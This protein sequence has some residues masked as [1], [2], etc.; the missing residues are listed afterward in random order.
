MN[1]SDAHLTH[2]HSSAANCLLFEADPGP[3][4]LNIG[5]ELEPRWVSREY[6]WR[7]FYAHDL[8]IAVNADLALLKQ[9]LDFAHQ[10]RH[11]TTSPQLTVAEQRE[12]HEFWDC[13]I[14]IAK[15]AID[16]ID[17]GGA[18]DDEHA[19]QR[20]LAGAHHLRTT[21]A[22]RAI[23]QIVEQAGTDLAKALDEIDKRDPNS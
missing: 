20:L 6:A 22:F 19:R 2:I 21:T 1:R 18:A 9:C 23:P 15:I 11:R 13:A 16:I 5:T 17:H 4:Q 12:A 10:E 3:Q 7:D 14:D 8:I